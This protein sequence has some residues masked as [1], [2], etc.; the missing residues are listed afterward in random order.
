MAK[1]P[2]N[3]N[4]VIE[5]YRSVKFRTE[6][7][8][9]D[10][11]VRDIIDK[12]RRADAAGDVEEVRRLAIEALDEDCDEE[13]KDSWERDTVEVAVLAP[14]GFLYSLSDLKADGSIDRE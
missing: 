14:N 10:P 7:S 6:L 11:D 9:G 3:S 5:G 2:K 1:L 8:T 4:V 13:L 12:L